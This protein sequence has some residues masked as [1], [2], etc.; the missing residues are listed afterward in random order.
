VAAHSAI[1]LKAASTIDLSMATV[2]KGASTVEAARPIE[3]SEI[4]EE[5]SGLA[6]KE[7]ALRVYLLLF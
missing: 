4:V 7:S 5:G 6:R 2:H 1:D 3:G